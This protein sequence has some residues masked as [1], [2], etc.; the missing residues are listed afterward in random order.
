MP[1]KRKKPKNVTF[2]RY[3]QWY[4]HL[5]RATSIYIPFILRHFSYGLLFEFMLLWSWY[6]KQNGSRSQTRLIVLDICMSSMNLSSHWDRSIKNSATYRSS[7]SNCTCKMPFSISMIITHLCCLN[8]I[9]IHIKSFTSDGTD[10]MQSFSL[11]LS[12]DS[13]QL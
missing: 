6:V 12:G 1:I 9:I 13:E 11:G 2:W 7:S 5:A 10:I 4:Q 8:L 3:A